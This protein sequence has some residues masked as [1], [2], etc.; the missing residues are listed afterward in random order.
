MKISRIKTPQRCL[1][2][3][4]TSSLQEDGRVVHYALMMEGYAVVSDDSSALH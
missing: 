3:H 2:H 4:E 1:G